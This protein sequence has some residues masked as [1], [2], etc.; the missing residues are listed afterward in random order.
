MTLA[1]VRC[2]EG[3]SRQVCDGQVG[4]AHRTRLSRRAADR[5]FRRHT[6]QRPVQRECQKLSGWRQKRVRI[7]QPRQFPQRQHRPASQRRGCQLLFAGT[8]FRHRFRMHEVRSQGRQAD[9]HVPHVLKRCGQARARMQ[10][11][12]RTRACRPRTTHHRGKR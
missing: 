5:R 2:A 6:S 7:P 11:A 12:P 8:S 3:N 4:Y 1:V 10:A 9:G